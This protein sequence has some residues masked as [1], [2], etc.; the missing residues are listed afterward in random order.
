[1]TIR[2]KGSKDHLRACRN[3][4]RSGK[5]AD[6]FMGFGSFLDTEIVGFHLGD[7][8]TIRKRDIVFPLRNFVPMATVAAV[9]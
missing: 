1:M 4:H 5:G 2:C 6:D 3:T 9:P 7:D 8:R